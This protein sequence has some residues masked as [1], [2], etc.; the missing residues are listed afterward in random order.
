MR[1]QIKCLNCDL[2]SCLTEHKQCSFDQ[3]SFQAFC[4]HRVCSILTSVHMHGI[5]HFS[6][7]SHTHSP[8]PVLWF[9]YQFCGA[10]SPS[11]ACWR[12]FV[13]FIFHYDFKYLRLASACILSHVN[14]VTLWLLQ[15]A[16]W[17]GVPFQVRLSLVC[18]VMP[19][20]LFL[21][22]INITDYKFVEWCWRRVCKT[23]I[24]FDAI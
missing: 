6:S 17:R 1:L 7:L 5:V 10:V 11:A 13:F 15:M 8:I 12:C 9:D 14:F 22:C 24:H 19:V 21:I 18:M 23:S 20:C 3:T 2:L 4:T 16:Q